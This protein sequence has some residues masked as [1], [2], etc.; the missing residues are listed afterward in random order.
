MLGKLENP[1]HV[2]CWHFRICFCF[3]CGDMPGLQNMNC[4]RNFEICSFESTGIRNSFLLVLWKVPIY[5]KMCNI[6]LTNLWKYSTRYRPKYAE[7]SWK[8][9]KTKWKFRPRYFSP[10]LNVLKSYLNC[11]APTILHS[12]SACNTVH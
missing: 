3:T 8:S 12:L 1:F 10:V 6:Y 2:K 4:N 7:L 11:N 9:V 5:W